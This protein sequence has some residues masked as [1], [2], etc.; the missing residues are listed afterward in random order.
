MEPRS[1]I[2][3]NSSHATW[4]RTSASPAFLSF[5][6]TSADVFL[7][8]LSTSMISGSS[9]SEP[10]QLA[11]RNRRSSCSSMILALYSFTSVL[12]FV[13]SVCSSG[14]SFCTTRSSSWSSRPFIVTV[15]SMMVTLADSSGVKC[16]FGRRVVMYSLNLSGSTSH[17][18]SAS[19]TMKP[20]PLRWNALSSTGSSTG[21]SVCSTLA[22]SIGLPKPMHSS[23]YVRNILSLKP[24]SRQSLA[25]SLFLIHCRPCPCGSTMIG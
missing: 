3:R 12:S 16:G 22:S 9:S 10:V 23:R 24:V 7:V 14:F 19:A 13:R 11:R 8:M 17:S 4:M 2:G 15:K 5:S 18:L 1:A 20:L 25:A 21:S 6:D